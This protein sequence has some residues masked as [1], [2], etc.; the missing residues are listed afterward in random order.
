MEAYLKITYLNDFIFCP[1]SIYYHEL[2][3]R[4]EPLLY[5]DMPQLNGKAAHQTIDNAKYSTN[6]KILQGTTVYSSKYALCGRID[7]F[8]ID[9]GILTERKKKISTI[10]DGYVYQL[11]AQCLCLREMGYIVKNIRFW[12]KD[13]NKIYPILLPE[14][15]PEKFQQFEEIINKLTGFN[16]E[17]FVPS[18]I[19]KCRSCIYRIFCDKAMEDLNDQH[20][21]F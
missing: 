15:D 16:L 1:M 5:H 20:Q 10:Y 7:T 18:N 11:Y 19:Q 4:T 13:D 12:S 2:F 6:K 3:G 14:D 9:K 8:D 21:R 17:S